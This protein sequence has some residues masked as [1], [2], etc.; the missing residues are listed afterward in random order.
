MKSAILLDMHIN[1]SLHTPPDYLS[2]EVFKVPFPLELI[3]ETVD[4][5]EFPS[6]VALVRLKLDGYRATFALEYQNNWLQR[7]FESTLKLL[8]QKSRDFGL[9]PL[10]VLPFLDEE[11]LLT[12]E[13]RSISG[14]DLCG[15]GFVRVPDHWVFRS[16]GNP[17]PFRLNQSLKNIY[18]GK[19]SLVGRTLLEQAVFT[20]AQTLLAATQKRGDLLSQSLLSRVLKV[21]REEVLIEENR[22]QIVLLQPEKLL[23]KLARAWKSRK[24]RVLWKGRVKD[25]SQTFLPTLFANAQQ[26]K[27]PTIMT[28]IGSVSY[29][30][31]LS[32]EDVAYLYTDN[33][34]RLLEGLEVQQDHRFVNLEL[35]A[36]PDP[37]VFFD[38]IIDAKGIHWAS[39]VQTYLELQEGDARFQEAAEFLK[40]GILERV[41][42]T[43][44]TPI[45]VL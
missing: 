22:S 34:L 7:S 29:H 13:Q 28:G 26:K 37:V 6:N 41:R 31:S 24:P 18:Q 8:E 2:A 36:P 43:L 27:I 3:W 44:A 14:L 19:S 39:R 35:H 15:N 17:N 4:S 40:Q 38:P 16:T 32:M 5:L 21:L 10:I 23:H 45:G 20:N 42:S 25:S 9:L 1:D 12:L 30:T 33:P 11:K